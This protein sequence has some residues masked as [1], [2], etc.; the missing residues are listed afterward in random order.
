MDSYIVYDNQFVPTL[1][2]WLNV[3]QVDPEDGGSRLLRKF[4]KKLSSYKA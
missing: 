1:S 3:I 4:G 2:T